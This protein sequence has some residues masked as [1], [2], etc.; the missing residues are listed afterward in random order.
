MTMFLVIVNLMLLIVCC[1]VQFMSRNKG[2]IFYLI[3]IMI[4]SIPMESEN[5]YKVDFG[6]I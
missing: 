3:L 4:R 1:N 5:K 2:K 6:F